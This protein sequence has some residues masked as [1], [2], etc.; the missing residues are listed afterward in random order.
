MI[1]LTD[2]QKNVLTAS[3]HL[4]VAGGPGSG[5]TTVSILKAAQVAEN[6]LAPEQKILFLS[7][8]RATVS[9]VW[10]A[11]DESEN[12]DQE[13]KKRIVVDTYH[14][15]FWS[16]IKTHGYLLELPRKLEVLTP[17]SATPPLQSIICTLSL[18]S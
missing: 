3:G 11:L 14:S 4:L 2:N 17:S 5:K 13:I 1:E 10:E 12:V 6:E 7:F 15:F 8:A 16:I 18:I 9:R